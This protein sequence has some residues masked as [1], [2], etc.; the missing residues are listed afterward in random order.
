MCWLLHFIT[1]V[2]CCWRTVCPV[3]MVCGVVSDRAGAHMWWLLHFIAGMRCCWRTV[4][5]VRVCQI[6]QHCS[7]AHVARRL[8]MRIMHVRQQITACCRSCT[9]VLLDDHAVV[10]VACAESHATHACALIDRTTHTFSRAC[11]PAR[12]GARMCGCRSR[13]VALTC[14]RHRLK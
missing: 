14:G 3:R 2:C 9:C 1:G 11:A 13:A 4:C 6:A 5:P 7:H 8:L 12:P 10:R